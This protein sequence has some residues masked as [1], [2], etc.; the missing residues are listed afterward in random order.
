MKVVFDTNIFISALVIPGSRAEEAYLRCLRGEFILYSSIAIL[1]ETAKK[2]REKFGWG[3]N[4]ITRFLKAITRGGNVIKTHPHLHVLVDEPDNRI[5]ECGA[6]A[7][8]DIIVTGDKHLLSLKNY[9]NI[10]IITL[11]HFLELLKKEKQTIGG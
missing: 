5:L 9:Q 8:A 2:L 6:A 10:S 3:E 7:E 4:N 1:T 11:S